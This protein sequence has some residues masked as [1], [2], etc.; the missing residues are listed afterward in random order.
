MNAVSRRSNAFVK[1][2]AAVLRT[3]RKE[4][5]LSQLELANRAGISH[6]YVGYIERELRCPTVDILARLA[7]ALETEASE[8]C[9]LAEKAAARQK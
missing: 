4:R 9:M 7:I 6:Q 2:L 8:I 3:M 1:A 5:K